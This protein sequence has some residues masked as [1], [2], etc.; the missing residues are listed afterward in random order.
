M[1]N[2]SLAASDVQDDGQSADDRILEVGEVEFSYGHLQVL[3]G[4][5]LDV[6]AGEAIALLGTNGA[7]KSTLLRAICG[8]E[9]PSAGRVLFDGQDITGMPAEK[10]AW[11]GITLISEGV[12]S[13]LT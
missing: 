3:F 4:I 1:R 6:K 9:R 10:L 8:L 2:A 13:S 7:G 12:R 11:N 5:S